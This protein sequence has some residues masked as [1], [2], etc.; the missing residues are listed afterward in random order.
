M[1]AHSL[2]GELDG[3]FAEAARWD[4]DRMAAI[5]RNA[6]LAWRVAAAGWL[7]AVSS[8]CALLLLMPLKRIDPF[9]IRVDNST[10]VVDVVP[11]YAGAVAMDEAVTRYFLTH[12]VTVCQRFN[13]STAES[14]YE[15]CGAFHTAQRNQAWYALW[16]ANNPNSPL[17]LHRDGSLT[18]AQV[19]SVSFFKRASG[20]SDLAQVRYMKSELPAAGSQERVTRWIATIQYAYAAPSKDPKLRRWNPLGFKIIEFSSE[21]EVPNDPQAAAPGETKETSP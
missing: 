19:Q 15:E 17:N 21:P 9:V 6:R 8:G 20:V 2:Q 16:Q 4:A 13:F 14:D 5:E 10:G 11:V 18:R 7:C 1:S 12:Y 3:Y